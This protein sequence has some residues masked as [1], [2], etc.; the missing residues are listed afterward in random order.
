MNANDP[1]SLTPQERELAQRLAQIVPRGEPS[2]ALDAHILAAAREA[3]MSA[4]STSTVPTA[5][6][7]KTLSRHGRVRRRWPVVLGVAASLVLALGVAWRMQPLPQA[8]RVQASAAAPAMRAPVTATQ[9][10][11]ELPVE[12]QAEN[13]PSIVQSRDA[14]TS[15][16]RAATL[17]TEEP[18]SVPPPPA[19]AEPSIVLDAPSPQDRLPAAEKAAAPSAIP[20][21]AAPQ[22][23]GT[24][25]GATPVPPPPAPPNAASQSD[26]A[27]DSRQNQAQPADSNT[28]KSKAEDSATAS[29][30][31]PAAD[32]PPAT[33]DAPAVRDAWLQ[34]IRSL[35]RDGNII[36]ARSSLHAFVRRYPSYPL[37]EDLRGLARGSTTSP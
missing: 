10:P 35:I 18:E 15:H 36:D 6:F 11:I 28:L 29:N 14:L 32:V 23:S 16:A 2:P 8:R 33:A 27:A 3:G 34:R 19:P 31:E 13:T 4:L 1:P 37:P 25:A 22:A 26:M 20:A 24:M 5:I 17:Q 21:P 12:S 30:D 9:A 7:T